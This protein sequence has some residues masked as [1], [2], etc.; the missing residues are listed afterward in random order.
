MADNYLQTSFLIDNLTQKDIDKFVKII[1]NT[2]ETP[3]NFAT[4]EDPSNKDKKQ[5]WIYGDTY[6]D[7][8]LTAK[9]IQKF[10]KRCKLDRIIAFEYSMTCSKMRLDEFGGG[11][12]VISMDKIVIETTQG[13]IDRIV[14]ENFGA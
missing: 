8:D 11:A 3:F 10:L 14:D 9:I 7:V 2:D 5:I 4:E 12:V 1:K 6:F 13:L